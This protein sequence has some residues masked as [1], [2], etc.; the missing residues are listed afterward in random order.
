MKYQKSS[1]KSESWTTIEVKLDANDKRATEAITEVKPPQ[2]TYP[3]GEATGR[4][5][6]SRP[7]EIDRD[8]KQRIY[9]L[10]AQGMTPTE[11]GETEDICIKTVD[12]ITQ[13]M[14]KEQDMIA[15]KKGL[16]KMLLAGSA[17]STKKLID[18]LSG[19]EGDRA[20][21]GALAV[22]SGILTQRGLETLNN[23]PEPEATINWSDLLGA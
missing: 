19:E 17:I 12:R 21:V 22:V 23:T 18:K 13:R 20:T 14:A 1:P 10:V 16:G 2:I 9:E 11:I 15:Y 4:D 5:K 3:T 8:K 6:G 7:I